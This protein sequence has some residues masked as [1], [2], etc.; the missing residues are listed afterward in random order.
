MRDAIMVALNREAM[1]ADGKP[2]K[3]LYLV[4]ETLVDLAVGGDMGAIH[5][6][7]DRI[8]GKPPAESTLIVSKRDATDWT[9]DELVAFIHDARKGV[10]G[11]ASPDGCGGE[12]DSVH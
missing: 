6:I 8:D 10:N 4:A 5:E 7:C 11:N 9:R 1:N 2:T 3:K 12:P